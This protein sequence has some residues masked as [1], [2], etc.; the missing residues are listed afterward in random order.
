MA[1]RLSRFLLGLGVVAAGMMALAGTWRDPWLWSYLGMWVILGTYAMS[2]LD[3]DLARERFR[4][5]TQGADKLSLAIIRA[6]ALAHL[7]MGALD[8]GRWHIAP[9]PGPLRA[10]ALAGTSLAGG[11]VFYA[12][13]RN[14]FFSSVVRIQTDRGHRLI[15]TGPYAVVRHPGYA[16][17]LPLMALSGL[18]LGSYL[19]AAAGLVYSALVLRRVIVE[20]AFL[21]ERLPGYAEY[22]RRVRY[23]LIPGVW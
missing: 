14:R 11:A 21:Q 17:M 16:G 13:S 12:M 5:P 23:R 6:V 8:S 3:D 20:D 22:T 2:V 15:D 1:Q 18:A 10:A 4:P 7:A 9:V 19:A